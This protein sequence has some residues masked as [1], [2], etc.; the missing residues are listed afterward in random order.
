MLARVV[1]LVIQSKALQ[2]NQVVKL[3]AVEDFQPKKVYPEQNTKTMTVPFAM[4]AQVANIPTRPQ[5]WRKIPRVNF[6]KQ[7]DIQV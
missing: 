7:V 5:A 1:F 4:L 2:Y 3:V 6:A